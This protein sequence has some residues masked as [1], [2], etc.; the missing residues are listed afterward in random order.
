MIGAQ[1]LGTEYLVVVLHA[2]GDANW[3]YARTKAVFPEDSATF[4]CEI[5]D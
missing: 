5:S 3:R 4:L 2:L 1:R